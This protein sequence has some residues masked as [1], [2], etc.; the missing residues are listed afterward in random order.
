[1]CHPESVS[2]NILDFPSDLCQQGMKRGVSM[3]QRLWPHVVCVLVSLM[4]MVSLSAAETAPEWQDIAGE[5]MSPACPGRT[6]INCTSGQ[7]EQWRELIRQKIAQGETKEQIIQYFV[8]IRGEEILA[9]PPK[10]GFAL[11]AWLFP[12]LVI[13]NGTGLILVLT[14]RWARKRPS[15]SASDVDL[16]SDTAPQ[17]HVSVDPYRARL[18]QELKDFTA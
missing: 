14:Y 6:L 7:S 9:A 17:S 12:V 2:H 10:R 11:T 1:V 15:R 5:L 8:G 18:Q 4:T 3:M 13:I 16:P